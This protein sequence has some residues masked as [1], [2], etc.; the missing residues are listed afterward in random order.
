MTSEWEKVKE[1]AKYG[2]LTNTGVSLTDLKSIG[3]KITQLP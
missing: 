3:E 1:N 2:P